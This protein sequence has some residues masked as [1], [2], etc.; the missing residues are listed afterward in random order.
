LLVSAPHANI[1]DRR[2]DRDQRCALGA[3]SLCEKSQ[4]RLPM[5]V[6]DHRGQPMKLSTARAPCGKCAR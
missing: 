2:I 5:A 6:P 3:K 1:V 4:I